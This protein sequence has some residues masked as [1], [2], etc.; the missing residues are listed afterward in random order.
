ML[1]SLD[2]ANKLTKQLAVAA[3]QRKA[4]LQQEVAKQQ[5]CV[6][7]HELHSNIRMDWT[8]HAMWNRFEEMRLTF[9]K[10]CAALLARLEDDP[11]DFSVAK[12]VTD[13]LALPLC[14]H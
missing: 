11:P 3:A 2:D 9:V 4:S 7:L 6:S 8:E 5:R 1:S 10:Q 14:V 12:K 13:R